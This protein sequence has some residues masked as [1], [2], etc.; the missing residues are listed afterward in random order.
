MEGVE[1]HDIITE[2]PRRFQGAEQQAPRAT[3]SRYAQRVLEAIYGIR[4]D[5]NRP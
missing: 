3:P 4:L 1:M 5:R 2:A